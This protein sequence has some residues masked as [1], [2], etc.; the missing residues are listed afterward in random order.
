MSLKSYVWLM[1]LAS[2][3]ALASFGGILWFFSPQNAGGAIL[4]LLF[5]SLFLALCGLFSLL[6]LYLRRRH[7]HLQELENFLGTSLREGTLL[8]GLLVGFL[9]M[10]HFGIFYWWLA[11]I[12]L[13]IV[14]AIEMVFIAQEK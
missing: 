4:L 2:I 7:R 12:F 11:L 8:S 9:L 6:A 10:Q 1:G 5:L 3:L 14:V 13:I